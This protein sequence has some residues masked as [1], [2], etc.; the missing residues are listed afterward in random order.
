MKQ[1]WR[2]LRILSVLFLVWFVSMSLG[3]IALVWIGTPLIRS[4]VQGVPLSIAFDWHEIFRIVAYS[5]GIAALASVLMW[6][7]GRFAGRW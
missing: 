6:V 4:V 5:A 2:N 1:P 3:Y 7:E